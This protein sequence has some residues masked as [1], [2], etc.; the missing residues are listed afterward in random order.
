M[1]PSD[2]SDVTGSTY[3]YLVNGRG[4]G[5][6]W[7]GLFVAGQ[8]VR[9]RIVNASAMTIFNLRIPGLAMT[10]VQADGQNVRPR[11]RR[12]TPDRGGRDL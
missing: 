1:D 9:L 2:V 8:R 10:V 4:P 12:R 6:N 11:H 5:D 7:T 3:R